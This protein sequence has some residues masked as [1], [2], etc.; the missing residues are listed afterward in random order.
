MAVIALWFGANQIIRPLQ[1]LQQ[2]SQSIGKGD[3]EQIREPV[4]GIE[5]IRHLQKQLILVS[6]ELQIAQTN[7]HH[8][9]GAITD[10]IENERRNLARELHDDTLQSLIALQQHIQMASMQINNDDEISG[11]QIKD[12][13]S[14][15]QK[16]ITN[17]R[18]LVRGLRPAYLD[19][20]GLV[21]AMEMLVNETNMALPHPIKLEINGEEHVLIGLRTC[22]LPY[23]PES[24]SNVVRHSQASEVIVKLRYEKNVISLEIQDNG[25]GF[26]FPDRTESF[27]ASSHF[28]LIGMKE[29]AELVNAKLTIRTFPQKGTAVQLFYPL[30][31]AK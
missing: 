27:A 28:G 12:L 30:I 19:D 7:I 15:L 8:Y 14:L 25:I 17:L 4:G 10:G 26:D 21:S 18:R 24:L 5:E 22:V 1:K 11:L 16:S 6:E 2:R 23:C 31:Q 29:R 13:R 3:L 9:I 20:L